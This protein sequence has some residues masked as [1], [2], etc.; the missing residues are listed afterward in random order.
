MPEPDLSSFGSTA[1][2]LARNPLG[3]IALFLVL[4]YG[5]AAL[6]L[7]VSGKNL[8]PAQRWPLV[9]FLVIFPVLVLGIFSWLVSRHHYKLYAPADHVDP[10]GF[11]KTFLQNL[12]RPAR[13][14]KVTAQH[15]ALTYSSWRASQWDEKYKQRVYRFDV[16]LVG[17]ESVLD[18]VDH[19]E[20][21]LPPAWPA[22]SSPKKV[23]D[24]P[25]RFKLKELAWGDLIV[26][27]EV[28]F[29]DQAEVL[30]L[31]CFVKLQE[32]GPRL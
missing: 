25:S 27:A 16:V 23:T 15:L 17:D 31:S 6:V 10:K 13:D 24:R 1:R 20:Y 19:V 21:F 28:H 29:R 7:G 2:H 8:E 3:I 18:R 5:F 4:V 11:E 32:A 12:P 26:K 14:E 30:P 9:W 22:S